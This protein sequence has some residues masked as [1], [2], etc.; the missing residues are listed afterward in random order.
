MWNCKLVK[1]QIK[2]MFVV[3]YK[4]GKVTNWQKLKCYIFQAV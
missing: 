3:L 2:K 1:I 4:C